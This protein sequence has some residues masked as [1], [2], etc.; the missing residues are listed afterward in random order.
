MLT[1]PQAPLE[2]REETRKG[3][4]SPGSGTVSDWSPLR[5]CVW[6]FRVPQTRAAHDERARGARVR[7]AQSKKCH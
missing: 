5:N 1:A 2:P 4:E 3:G 7:G 6:L